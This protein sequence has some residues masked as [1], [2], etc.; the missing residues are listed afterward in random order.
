VA[1]EIAACPKCGEIA[2]TWWT[3]GLADDRTGLRA[4]E[5]AFYEHLMKQ[6]P[7]VPLAGQ[8]GC[9]DCRA[10]VAMAQLALPDLAMYLQDGTP[11][12][13]ARLHF[14]HHFLEQNASLGRATLT[15]GHA[16]TAYLF[17]FASG[18]APASH[19]CSPD[20]GHPYDVTVELTG[21]VRL[22]SDNQTTV[23]KTVVAELDR[24]L[25]HRELERIGDAGL[26]T[27][28][29]FARWVHAT[30]AARLADELAEGLGVRVN[31][32]AVEAGSAVFPPSAPR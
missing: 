11:V 32:P 12:D 31:A 24:D 8:E 30:V 1:P 23:L 2:E 6:H 28:D 10:A 19:T 20:R 26:V 5:L 14:V 29:D 21:P 17:H 22:M 4:D 9:N 18:G 15:S 7:T 3:H 25:Q 27:L 13:T 16:F